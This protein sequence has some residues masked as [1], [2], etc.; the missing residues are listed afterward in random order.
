M[1]VNL[2]SDISKTA[3]PKSS[4]SASLKQ[5]KKYFPTTNQND[6]VNL[7]SLFLS[8]IF[9]DISKR[10]AKPFDMFTLTELTDPTKRINADDLLSECK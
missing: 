8:Y 6:T 4:Q 5:V 7:L 1:S 3:Y 10:S 2:S 9:N